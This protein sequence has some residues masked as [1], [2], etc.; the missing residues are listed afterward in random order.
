M[1]VETY[2]SQNLCDDEE[3]KLQVE[4]EKELQ[5]DG[6]WYTKITM[7][8][9]SLPTTVTNTVLTLTVRTAN[10]PSIQGEDFT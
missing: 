2:L 5:P 4:I 10:E 1:A 7:T 6:S 3:L 8:N 9:Q